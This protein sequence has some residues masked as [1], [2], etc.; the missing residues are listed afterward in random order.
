[1]PNEKKETKYT[2]F[3]AFEFRGKQYKAGDPFTPGDATRDAAGEELL[4]LSDTR[5]RGRQAPQGIPFVYMTPNPNPKGE[6]ISRRV[7]LPVTEG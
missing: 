4:R 3:A 5:K 1:M 6:A 2:A 7:I